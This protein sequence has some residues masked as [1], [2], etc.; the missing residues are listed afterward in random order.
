MTESEVL[1]ALRE[2][3]D[4]ELGANV[5]DLGLVYGVEVENGRVRVAMTMTSRACPLSVYVAEMAEAAIRAREPLLEDVRV[6]IVWDPP[7]SPER[8]A[9]PIRRMLG[10]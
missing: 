8:M 2:V 10:W 6:E 4:P 7:W 9:E 1:D 5:V 3:V